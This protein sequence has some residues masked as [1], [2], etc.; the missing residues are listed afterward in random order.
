MVDG[1]HRPRRDRAG[2]GFHIDVEPLPVPRPPVPTAFDTGTRSSLAIRIVSSGI[3]K[4]RY[5]LSAWLLDE[6]MQSAR[7]SEAEREMSIEDI[8]ANVDEILTWTF[9]SGV[10]D[11]AKTTVEFLLPR[12]LLDLPVDRW[13][14][15]ASPSW[16]R[17]VGAE[18]PVVIR[19]LERLSAQSTWR[20]WQRKW[21]GLT[22]DQGDDAARV[23]WPDGGNLDDA[24]CMVSRRSPAGGDEVAVAISAGIPVLVW[25]RSAQNSF[26][27]DFRHLLGGRSLS[28]LPEVVANLRRAALV[29]PDTSSHLGRDIV[30]MWDDPGRLPIL[31]P[32][33]EP[34]VG[35][36]ADPL[37]VQIV[38]T[39]GRVHGTGVLIDGRHVLTCAHVVVA[40]VGQD[41][42][43]TASS[44]AVLVRA[45]GEPDD[46]PQPSHVMPNAWRRAADLAVLALDAPLARQVPRLQVRTGTLTP[47]VDV[48]M[49]GYPPG[50]DRGVWIVG[51][52][53]DDQAVGGRMRLRCSRIGERLSPGHSGGP[54]VDA[55]SGDIVG[56]LVATARPDGE[57][58]LMMPIDAAVA[59]WPQFAAHVT[60]A[61]RVEHPPSAIGLLQ[62]VDKCMDVR[63]LAVRS[64]RQRI[65]RQ[66]SLDVSSRIVRHPRDRFD[67]FG[68]VAA[69]TATSVATDELIAML[70]RQEGMTPALARVEKALVAMAG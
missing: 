14:I 67:I 40:A 17:P 13:N 22:D 32:T 60:N 3:D 2:V 37:T 27:D 55:A 30:L 36:H 9:D 46:A 35:R 12:D 26:P 20:T 31:D 68:L 45:T 1:H 21:D 15:G 59:A 51:R 49:F 54:V 33:P 53:V 7:L 23:V 28:D 39:T 25:S 4:S 61:R 34:E 18:C 5:F 10:V 8:R 62:I 38:D 64:R 42:D 70:R 65:V 29:G 58:G 47:D 57:E 11:R 24:L 48:R 44:A 16:R 52:A 63:T 56:L 41:D 69:C 50:S 66:L 6:S 19:S 43:E